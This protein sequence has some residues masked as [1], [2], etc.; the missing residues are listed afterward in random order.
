MAQRPGF[1][2]AR[3]S[4]ASKILLGASL[5]YV[6]DSFLPWNRFCFEVAGITGGCAGVSLW[7][8]V[9][10]IA[11]LLAIALLVLEALRAFGTNLGTMPQRTLDMVSVGLAAGIVLFTILRIVIDSEFL[12]FG[13]WIGIV[14]ALALA[15]G[16]YMRWQE[17]KAAPGAPGP[18]PPPAASPPPPPPS[19]GFTS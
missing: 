9:G 7:H 18:P 4:T 2:M 8:G 1:D 5:L 11:G 12:S 10:L 19:G 16:G 14:L 3:M 17:A 6:I 13:A 15:Y